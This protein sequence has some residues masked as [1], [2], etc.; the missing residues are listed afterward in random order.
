M[1]QTIIDAIRNKKVLTFTYDGH[2]RTVEPHTVGSSRAGNDV[3]RCF[4]TGGSHATGGHDWNLCTVSKITNLQT[5]GSTFSGP[6][7]GYQRGDKGMMT[8]YAEL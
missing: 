2:S 6:R 4:Q 3:F 8:I 1:L 5:P 7:P